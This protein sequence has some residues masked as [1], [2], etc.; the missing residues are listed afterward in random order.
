VQLALIVSFVWGLF[1]LMTYVYSLL[2][3]GS[4]NDFLGSDN[5]NP[6]ANLLHTLVTLAIAGTIFVYYWRDEHK[7]GQQ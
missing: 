5:T 1:R 3:G 6:V 7:K 2:N 4:G